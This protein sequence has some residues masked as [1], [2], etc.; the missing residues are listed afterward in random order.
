MNS[1]NYHDRPI[2]KALILNFIVLIAVVAL[3][4]I[5]IWIINEWVTA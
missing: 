4:A 2:R 1:G 3:S 5:G